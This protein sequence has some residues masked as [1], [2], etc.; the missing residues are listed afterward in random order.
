MKHSIAKLG[1]VAGLF[2]ASSLAFAAAETY[3]IDNKHS[4]ANFAIRHVVS[5]TSGTFSDIT[6]KLVIDKDN[7][8]KSSVDA[9]INVLSVNTS[10]EKRDEHI[11]KEEYLN[12]G[13][14]GE[15]HFVST[16][17]EPTSASQGNVTGKLTINGVTKDVTFPFAVLGF[18]KDPWGGLR[19]GIEAKT[20]IRASDYGY[21]WG[22]PGSPV[23]DDVEVTL[24][25]EG[26]K[27]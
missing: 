13:K 3:E 12:A 6:G 7:L 17:I 5:K 21:S 26:V 9:K 20:I 24:L 15:I 4:F 11:K 27:K 14:F 8:A 10:N 1:L 2:A 19:T 23:G 16:K 18:G 22:K 25:I